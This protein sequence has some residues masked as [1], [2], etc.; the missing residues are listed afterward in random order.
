[1]PTYAICK[2]NIIT[3]VIIAENEESAKEAVDFDQII[4]TEG[5]PWIGWTLQ[6]DGT[7][8]SEQP[9]PS[10]SWNGNEWVAPLPQPDNGL[11]SWDEDSQSWIEQIPSQIELVNE[12]SE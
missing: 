2:N 11:Y 12:K 9:Y 10:W 6:D 7:W 8:R 3:N 5:E 1:M 4:E